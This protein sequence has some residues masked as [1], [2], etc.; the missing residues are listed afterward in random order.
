MDEKGKDLT[1][2]NGEEYRLHWDLTRLFASDEEWENAYKQT[3]TRAASFAKRAGTLNGGRE[4][5]LE[6][7][8]AY[9]DMKLCLER[10]YTYA[11]MKLHEDT[12]NG[13]YQ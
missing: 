3:E 9:M 11:M 7:L 12:S 6:V 13:R 4:T 2:K 8:S 5:V 1:E 10:L